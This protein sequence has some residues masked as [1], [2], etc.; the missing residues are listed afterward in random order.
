MENLK[1]RLG[2]PSFDS[3]LDCIHSH[4]GVDLA[5]NGNSR[6]NTANADAAQCIDGKQAVSGSLA[7]LYTQDLGELVDDL[8][9]ALNIAGSTQAAA[10][11]ILALRLQREEG[12]EGDNTVDLSH[13]DAGFLGNEL[14]DFQSNLTPVFNMFL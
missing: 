8:L 7:G 2:L 9:S 1:Y 14:L 12:I 11:D 3:S 4:L 6:S 10:D 13:G 5:I